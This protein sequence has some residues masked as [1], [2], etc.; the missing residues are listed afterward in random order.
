MYFLSCVYL[1]LYL[2]YKHTLSMWS[3]WSLSFSFCWLWTITGSLSLSGPVWSPS[4][5]MW[6]VLDQMWDQTSRRLWISGSFLCC[7]PALNLQPYKHQSIPAF[8][9]LDLLF[10][11]KILAF[12]SFLYPVNEVSCGKG[13]NLPTVP[14][15]DNK[16]CHERK[17]KERQ[18][19][20]I[21]QSFQR[22][23]FLTKATCISPPFPVL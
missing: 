4:G 1:F 15:E 2:S 23:W 10:Q 9:P 6:Y 13:F 20:L 17:S 16:Y 22:F 5:W 3:V 12:L 14:C 11:N 18:F 21:K 8:V 19:T 7:L